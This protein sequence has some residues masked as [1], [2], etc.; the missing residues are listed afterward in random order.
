MEGSISSSF[1]FSS[2]R[3]DVMSLN[4]MVSCSHPLATGIG[5]DVLKQGGNAMDA[6]VAMAA[7]LNVLEPC[8][9]GIGGDMF[10]LFYEASSNKVYAINGSGRSPAKLTTAFLKEKKLMV[11]GS[12]KIVEEA[13][14]ASVT[15]P[16][17]CAG[18][19]DALE[20]HG[21]KSMK[22]LLEPAIRLAEEG[23]PVSEITAYFWKAQEFLLKKTSAT[24]LLLNGEAP[25]KGDVFRNP[26]LAKTFRIISEKDGRKKFYEGEIADAIVKAVQK[27]G[28][29]LEKEDLV[30]HVSTFEEPISTVWKDR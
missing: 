12:D 27:N 6:C 1:S 21:T 26:S 23:F 9:T 24:D 19:F 29:V 8:S 17:A 3:S 7:S 16:G 28:G 30:R 10:S 2:R 22:D 20:K 4:G 18:W 13:H 5:I 15:V 25:S 11:E 14:A